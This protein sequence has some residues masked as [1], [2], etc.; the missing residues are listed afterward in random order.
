MAQYLKSSTD[1][2]NSDRRQGTPESHLKLLASPAIDTGGIAKNIV[3]TSAKRFYRP[4]LDA[5]RFFAFFAVLLHHGPDGGN[6]L[7][8][9]RAAG[10]F[11]LSMFF[12]LSGY[13]I[14]E[15][16][17]R[18]R[19]QTNTVAWGL[20]FKRRALRIWP[21][22]YAALAVAI[23]LAVIPPHRYWVSPSGI[24]LMSVF[25]ANWTRIGSQ[26]GMFIGQL[27]SISVEEQFYL[28]WPPIIKLGG[29]TMALAASTLFAVSAGVWLYVFSGKGWRLWYD[30]PVEFV[31]FAAGAIL[32]LVTR[33][34]PMASVN[35][36]IRVALLITGP[37]LLLI[38]A[39][40]GG[41]GTD[42]IAGLSRV[43]L[44]I[45]YSG[46]IAGCVSIF[47]AML[48]MSGIPP[49]LI[50]L[51]KISY[52][53]YVFHA[54]MLFLSGC[55][56]SA[57]GLTSDGAV[58]MLFV[59]GVALLLSILVAHLSYRYFESPFLRFKERFAVIESRPA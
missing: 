54:G 4:E 9:V 8:L 26:L 10:G 35:G 3:P 47:L 31:F 11:G 14:T 27:W 18:E 41:V 5:L 59:D 53:L 25:V 33:G 23:I 56:M 46:A 42:D 21:L 7:S 58:N 2:E 37:S 51:G 30:T 17:C 55:F 20:F 57:L 44:Y 6:F 36:V 16:L 39:G 19:E 38:A 34:K 40:I 28:I 52:G 24:V 45:G 32:A 43:R 22:Y 50:Y 12:L 49:A 48:G 15:L 13:L 1:V 29:K